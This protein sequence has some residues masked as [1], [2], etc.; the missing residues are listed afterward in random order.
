MLR[1]KLLATTALCGVFSLLLTGESTQAADLTGYTA[2]PPM[3]QLP[4]VDG[5]NGK[6]DAFGG[7]YNRGAIGGMGGS[8]SLPIGQSFG[9]QIDGLAADLGGSAYGSVSD[10]LFWRNPAAGLIGLFFVVATLSQSRERSQ[11]LRGV[12]IYMTPTVLNFAVVLSAS[13]VAVA[14]GVATRATAVLIGLGAAVGLGNALWACAGILNRHVSGEP[15]HWSD[16]WLY[17]AVPTS[18]HVGLVIAVV[19]LWCGAAW[20]PTAIGALLLALLLVGVRN[21]WDLVTWMA[22][23]GGPSRSG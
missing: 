7:G 2:P 8:V 20:S 17:G 23:G 13:A 18:I 3:A 12:S 15:P 6:L 22:P 19:G 10:H 4:A 16:F 21:G 9:T 5:V 1:P 11:V 14:P